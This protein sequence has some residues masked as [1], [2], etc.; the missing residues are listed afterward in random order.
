MLTHTPSGLWALVPLMLFSW[1][2]AAPTHALHAL[3]PC[4]QLNAACRLRLA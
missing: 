2:R 3:W 1:L 4:A